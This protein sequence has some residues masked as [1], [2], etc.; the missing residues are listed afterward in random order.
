VSDCADFLAGFSSEESAVV[1]AARR[2]VAR[3][4]RPQVA[5]REREAG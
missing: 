5:Q 3:D 2:F 1:E 4:V